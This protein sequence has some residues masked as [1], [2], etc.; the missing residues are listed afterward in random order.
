MKWEELRKIDSLHHQL[1]QML[2]SNSH[3]QYNDNLAVLFSI[4]GQ[5]EPERIDKIKYMYELM[6]RYIKVCYEDE[7]LNRKYIEQTC[8]NY[9]EFSIF[10]CYSATYN[11]DMSKID[12][13]K[14]LQYFYSITSDEEKIIQSEMS[15]AFTK[16]C[17]KRQKNVEHLVEDGKSNFND[18]K[19][20]VNKTA[21]NKLETNFSKLSRNEFISYLIWLFLTMLLVVSIS[22]LCISSI[23]EYYNVVVTNKGVITFESFINKAWIATLLIL[24]GLWVARQCAI[25][26]RQHIIYRHLDNILGIFPWLIKQ[27]GDK[28]GFALAEVIKAVFP[29]PHTSEKSFDPAAAKMMSDI[30]QVV[31]TKTASSSQGNSNRT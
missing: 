5:K 12:I 30:L 7:I 27:T 2:Q 10:L 9:F 13:Q 28:E 19:A 26:R 29:I 16:Y 14:I 24:V 23:Y 6:V 31:L 4:I 3:T 8:I 18:I 15:Y 17:D 22:V 25:A 11:I 20:F 1:G 21:F